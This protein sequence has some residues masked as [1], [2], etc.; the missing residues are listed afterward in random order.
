LGQIDDVRTVY[1]TVS[2]V[3]DAIG[4]RPNSTAPFHPKPK[5]RRVRWDYPFDAYM[6]AR[7]LAFWYLELALLW[8]A[9]YSGWHHPRME[10]DW[11]VGR[12]DLVPWEDPARWS[13]I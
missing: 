12:V 4:L 6:D 13:L 7:A 5:G 1:V 8:I 10:R 11:T 3:D 9:G 2:S